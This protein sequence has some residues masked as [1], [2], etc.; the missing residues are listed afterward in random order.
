[1]V[2]TTTEATMNIKNVKKLDDEKFEIR[3][4]YLDELTG[5][6]RRIRRR[7]SGTLSEAVA[8]RD[9]LKRQVKEGGLNRSDSRSDCPLSKWLDEFIQHKTS[10]GL[11]A[12][13]MRSIENVLDPM[14]ET[15]VGHWRPENVEAHHLDRWVAEQRRTTDLAASTIRK[16][17]GYLKRLI[18]YARK[19]LRLNVGFL[20]DVDGVKG[21]KQQRGRAL[22][23]DEA[24]AFLDGMREEFPQHF[25]LCFLLLATGQR[26]GAVTALRWDDIDDEWI[27]FKRSHYRGVV[28]EGSKTGKVIRIPMTDQ[29]REILDWHRRWMLEHQHPNLETGLV[30]PAMTS[31]S[32]SATDGYRVAGDL[33]GPFR[34]VCNMV[35]ID[36]TTPHDLRRTFNSWAAERVSGTV[37]RS[38]TGHSSS[39]MTDHYYHGSREA[40]GDVVESIAKLVELG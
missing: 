22:S 30:F 37:L 10:K 12:S 5:Q 15:E 29:L 40:K 13:S 19:N 36:D 34:K 11:R 9:R 39:T 27:A 38:I 25:G 18:R 17:L 7:I 26:F 2:A 20:R 23:P 1:M 33:R 32:K 28:D 8:F 3:F 6:R 21:S 14:M 31:V 16:R 35:D 24:G 4:S